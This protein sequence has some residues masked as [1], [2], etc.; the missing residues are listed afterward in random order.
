M[1][2]ILVQFLAYSYF[3]LC[4]LCFYGGFLTFYLGFECGCCVFKI[5]DA[6]VSKV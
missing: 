5:V 6:L 3:Y 2:C 1:V 4:M